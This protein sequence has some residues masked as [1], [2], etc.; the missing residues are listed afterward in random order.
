[1]RFGSKQ[2]LLERNEREHQTF[3][4]LVNS[5]PRS[6]YREKGV[7]G[8]S[9]SIQD[10]LAHLMEWEQMFLRWY[11]EGRDGGNPDLPAPGYKW[12]QIRELNRTIWRKH[13]RS[14]TKKVI[15]AFEASYEEILAMVRQL[16]SE[17]LL[18]PGHFAWTGRY[19]LTTY[20][21]PNTG[22]H[23]R[24]ATRVLKRWLKQQKV[25]ENANSVASRRT[26]P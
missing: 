5:V 3:V 18:T 7:W 23:Y 19:P 24:F 12:N 22:S 13:H 21:A 1:M 11:R 8:D 26:R 2:E 16:S 6:H 17:E 4:E 10:L 15:E 14:S 25:K 9:W 20:L